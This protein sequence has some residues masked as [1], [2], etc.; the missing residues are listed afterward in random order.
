MTG[1]PVKTADPS[2]SLLQRI[3]EDA[4]DPGYLEAAER[5]GR[6]DDPAHA[7]GEGRGLG[8]RSTAALS[9]VLFALGLLLVATVL[10]VRQGAPSSSETRAELAQRVDSMTG[11]VGAKDRQVDAL[12]SRVQTR[13][14]Q[15]LAGSLADQQ[16][17]AEVS[18]LEAQVGASA[19]TG[20]GLTVTMTDGPPSAASEGGPDLARVLDTDIQLVVNGLFASGAEAVSVNGQRVTSLSPI[21]TA[22]EAVLVGFRP[23]TPPY[24]I[25]AIGPDSLATEF[26]AST[27]RH[28]LAGLSGAYGIGV[29][30]TERDEVTVPGRPDLQVRYAQEVPTPGSDTHKQE[31]S[32]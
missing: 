26:E 24:V 31:G 23:L 22:G 29:D 6:S 8:W 28:E 14:E 27:A 9:V 12:S 4:M 21:R 19:A 18:A 17:A 30:I 10:Q 5:A 7:E 11:T 16:L 25:A 32:P 20:P 13:R 15:A 3:V 2:L 1:A